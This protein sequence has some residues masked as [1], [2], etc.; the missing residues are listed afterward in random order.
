MSSYDWNGWRRCLFYKSINPIQ[1]LLTSQRPHL[2]IPSLGF[3]IWI[4]WEHK[5]SLYKMVILSCVFIRHW[6]VHPVCL[7]S[8]V[9]GH[10]KV[11]VHRSRPMTESG[12]SEWAADSIS[13]CSSWQ[14]QRHIP[15]RDPSTSNPAE[16]RTLPTVSM[17]ASALWLKPWPD[18]INIVGKSLRQLTLRAGPQR[19]LET[20]ICAEL[21]KHTMWYT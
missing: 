9:S 17:M 13:L 10:E 1:D 6:G 19:G 15:R 16:T 12:V 20:E 18:P 11:S 4:L 14:I 7:V 8:K 3:N 2:L 21:K 5:H